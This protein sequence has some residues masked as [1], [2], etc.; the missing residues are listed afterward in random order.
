M[1]RAA[2]QE[3][4]RKLLSPNRDLAFLISAHTRGGRVPTAEQAREYERQELLDNA[5]SLDS[6]DYFEEIGYDH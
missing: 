3:S 5:P 2:A 1:T 6:G 4:A